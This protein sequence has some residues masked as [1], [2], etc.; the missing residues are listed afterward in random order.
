[1]NSAFTFVT[2]TGPR[3]DSRGDKQKRAHV[4]RRNVAARRATHM[5][6]FHALLAS[7]NKEPITE[8]ML[9]SGHELSYPIHTRAAAVEPR[10]PQDN[11]SQDPNIEATVVDEE[12]LGDNTTKLFE[13]PTD[14]YLSVMYCK[15]THPALLLYYLANTTYLVLGEFRLILFPMSVPSAAYKETPENQWVRLVT[16]EPALLEASLAVGLG[17]DSGHARKTRLL[18]EDKA[19]RWY[20]HNAEA[21]RLINEKLSLGPEGL[22]DGVLGAVFTLAFGEVSCQICLWNDFI[23]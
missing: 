19:A 6:Q 10:D 14:P 7:E 8:E 20:Q 2:S 15:M 17:C 18:S 21:C 11:R 1:M 9:S 23:F 13:S 5:Q 12:D 3:L 22:S 16:S 4:T